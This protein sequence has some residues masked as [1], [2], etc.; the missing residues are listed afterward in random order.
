MIGKDFKRYATA[1]GVLIQFLTTDREETDKAFGYIAK[2]KDIEVTIKPKRKKRSLDANAYLWVLLDKI[3]KVLNSTKENVYREIVR[4][5]GVFD[6]VLVPDKAVNHFIL[7][8][9]NNGL[10]WIT[11]IEPS[12]IKGGIK[13]RCYYGSS[14]YDT[15]QMS[16]LIDETV[17]RAK[18]LGIE[19]MP[20]E[21]LEALE[22]EWAK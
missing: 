4:D 8:W 3:A 5:V 17:Y 20:P 1:E 10:G 13:I 11:E 16:R 9:K 7:A 6:Y 19:T 15:E 2:G 21:E 18:E 12:K 22:R 14:T